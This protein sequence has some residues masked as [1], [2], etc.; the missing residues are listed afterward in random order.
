M[1]ESGVVDINI[2]ELTPEGVDSTV[3]KL[4]KAIRNAY[5]NSMKLR[6]NVKPYNP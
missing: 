2:S 1:S 6:G 5:F 4:T 3:D